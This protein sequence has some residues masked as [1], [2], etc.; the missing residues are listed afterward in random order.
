MPTPLER[1]PNDDL[2]RYSM[3]SRGELE[4]ELAR[5]LEGP[6]GTLPSIE[7]ERAYRIGLVLQGRELVECRLRLESAQRRLADLWAFA[8]LACL[9]L[10]RGGRVRRLSAQAAALLGFEV[11]SLPAEI[12]DA[13]R[14]RD[15][16]LLRRFVQAALEREAD[17]EVAAEDAEGLP[18]TLRFIGR[19]SV[20]PDDE[21]FAWIA[22]IDTTEGRRRTL[23]AS[24]L[25]KVSARLADAPGM[26]E[27]AQEVGRALVPAFA[28]LALFSVLEGG[29]GARPHTL[30]VATTPERQAVVERWAHANGGEPFEALAAHVRSVRQARSLGP[31][32]LAEAPGLPGPYA[33][34]LGAALLA[35]IAASES[36]GALLIARS[37]KGASFEDGDL[38]LAVQ[39]AGAALSA[40][41]RLASVAR[42]GRR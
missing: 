33:E 17:C 29:E 10:D 23:R 14:V 26:R 39:V 12:L 15:R 27:L 8:P 3:M 40:L 2:S 19:P 4:P 21:I 28:D 9:T 42:S 41:E 18:G 20:A 32:A 30:C 11:G 13:P 22:V 24:I 34:A 31:G 1:A 16:G 7:R 25:K 38:G 36:S 37:S 35:P 5:L 6:P